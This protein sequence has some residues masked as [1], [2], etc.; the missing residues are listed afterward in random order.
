MAIE[1]L[2]VEDAPALDD[3]GGT[4]LVDCAK[5]G[6]LTTPAKAAAAVVRTIFFIFDS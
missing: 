6:K 2:D 4:V 5:A 3:A 1:P